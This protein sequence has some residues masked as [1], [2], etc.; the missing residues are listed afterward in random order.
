ML[1]LLRNGWPIWLGICNNGI[2]VYFINNTT[3]TAIIGIYNQLKTKHNI[4]NIHNDNLKKSKKHFLKDFF[5]TS[6][7]IDKENSRKTKLKDVHNAIN[8]EAVRI[9]KGNHRISS[10]LQEV[11]R[12]I[13]AVTGIK[14]RDFIQSTLDELEYRKFCIEI[15]RCLKSKNFNN[16][17]HCTN[18]VRKQFRKK[19]NIIDNAGKQVDVEKS[20]IEISNK[21]SI[22]LSHYHESCYSSIHSAKGLEATSVLSIAYSNNELDK[23]L[24]FNAANKDLDDDYRL[25]YVAFSRARD[26]LCIACLGDISNDTKNKLKSLNIVFQPND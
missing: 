10:I 24:N 5:L 3:S 2:P 19:F 17:E 18:F 20:L 13:L 1:V 11:S 25:G 6:D 26:M 21:T 8:G 12:C 4:D 15:A 9:E 16:Y 23:W 14:K 7:W 22:N